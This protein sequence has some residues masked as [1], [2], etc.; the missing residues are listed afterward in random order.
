[1]GKGTAR[2][3]KPSRP[4]IEVQCEMGRDVIVIRDIEL[5]YAT[6]SCCLGD[7]VW[8]SFKYEPRDRGGFPGGVFSGVIMCD[9]GFWGPRYHV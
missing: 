4:V 9:L 7:A 3:R 8:G 1:M 5:A 6:L 2:T